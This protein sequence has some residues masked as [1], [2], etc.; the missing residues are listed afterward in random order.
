[1]LQ[2]G[3]FRTQVYG[4]LLLLWV[5]FKPVLITHPSYSPIKI[6]KTIS[7]SLHKLF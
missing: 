5:S 2:Q 7:F 1:M 6:S 4:D 3:I